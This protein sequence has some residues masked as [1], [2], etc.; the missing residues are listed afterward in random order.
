MSEIIALFLCGFGLHQLRKFTKKISNGWRDLVHYG[1]GSLGILLAWPV[2]AERYQVP[3]KYVKIGTVA[4][5]IVE[6]CIGVGVTIGW[7]VD[8]LRTDEHEIKHKG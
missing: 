2:V 1:I 6:F 4:L 3:H 8:T 7:L 5:A